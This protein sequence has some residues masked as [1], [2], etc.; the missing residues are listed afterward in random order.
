MPTY[1]A[2]DRT[3][4]A[5]R[6]V[7]DGAP[8]LCLPGGPMQDS[9]YLEELGGLSRHRRLTVPDLRGTGRSEHPADSSSYRCDRLVD[10]VEA[11]R[12]HLGLHRIDLLGHS[13]GANLAA[14]YT[15]RHPE[16]VSTLTLV[17]PG[18]AAVGLSASGEQRLALARCRAGEPWYPAAYAALEAVTAGRGGGPEWG[19]VAPFFHGRWDAEARRH[20]AAAEVQRN[21]EAAGIFASAGAFEPAGTRAALAA[22]EGRVLV[23]AGEFDVNS[24]PGLLADYADLFPR[25]TFTVQAGAGHYPWQDDADRF[26]STLAGFLA[27]A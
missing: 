8:L 9:A 25:A 6:T 1:L 7:G 26:V 15:A 19:A 18:T 5:Y 12:E 24:P 22:F 4:L 11:L 14:L 16:R 2:P 20:H 17:T 27:P 3:R 21:A 13:A 10:D 23:L